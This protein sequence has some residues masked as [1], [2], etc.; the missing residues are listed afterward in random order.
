MLHICRGTGNRR[1][2]RVGQG[3]KQRRGKKAKATTS[4][5]DVAMGDNCVVKDHV[6]THCPEGS[7]DDNHGD[8]CTKNAPPI[9]FTPA[10]DI[11]N[12]GL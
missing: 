5:D 3:R 7:N 4:G 9:V 2:R 6:I 8:S 12:E 1:R 11:I 10:N